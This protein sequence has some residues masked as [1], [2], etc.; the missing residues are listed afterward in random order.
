MLSTT[1]TILT[2]SPFTA[3]PCAYRLSTELVTVREHLS[4]ASKKNFQRVVEL[5]D[6]ATATPETVEGTEKSECTYFL[7]MDQR[8]FSVKKFTAVSKFLDLRTLLS[9]AGGLEMTG[10]IEKQNPPG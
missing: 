3:V 8:Q 5:Y 9:S 6:T 10:A 7:K 4:R 2:G 1:T